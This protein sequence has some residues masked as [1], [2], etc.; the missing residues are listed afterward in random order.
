MKLG[1]SLR[2]IIKNSNAIEWVK[3]I[4]TKSVPLDLAINVSGVIN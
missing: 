1:N 4:K 2:E 3:K